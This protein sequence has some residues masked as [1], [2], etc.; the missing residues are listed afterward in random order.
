MDSETRPHTLRRSV[1]KYASFAELAR[2]EAHGLDYRVRTI[3]RPGSA[4]LI[5]APH[6]GLIEAGT[7]EIAELIAGRDHSLF[8]F[9]GLKPHGANRQLH[10]TSHQFDHPEFLAL[11]ARCET[12]IGIHGCLGQTRIHV[13]GL[14]AELGA[15]LATHLAEAAFSVEA[16]S[17]RYPGLHPLNICNRGSSGRGGQL[18][19]THDLRCGDSPQ[20]ATRAAIARAV[21]SAI[22]AR[23]AHMRLDTP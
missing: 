12:V 16:R 7:S 20:D 14:D 15:I 6:G 9:E 18:E 22:A 17:T 23:L 11:A 1:G 21:R 10:I 13:G 5:A 3:E 8:L 19:I 2:N 4:V